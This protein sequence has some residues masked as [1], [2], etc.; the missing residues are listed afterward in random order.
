VQADY[1]ILWTIPTLLVEDVDR[2]VEWYRRALG[3]RLCTATGHP[4]SLGIIELAPGRAI[5]LKR[6]PHDQVRSNE[7]AGVWDV[8]IEVRGL[9]ELA[10]AL[11][12]RGVPVLRGPET[13]PY[14][15]AELELATPDG[16]RIC[17]AEQAE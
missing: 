8:Y 14:A 4:T 2:S 10:D 6:A 3:F 17:F 15:M 7:T 9:A 5:H 13:M 12:R 11:H 16:H 1:E